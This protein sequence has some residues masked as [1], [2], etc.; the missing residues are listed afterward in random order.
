[1]EVYCFPLWFASSIQ[2]MFGIF[3]YI[4]ESKSSFIFIAVQYSIISINPTLFIHLV[5]DGELS[6]SQFLAIVYNNGLNNLCKVI[7]YPVS[8][9]DF[10]PR[11]GIAEL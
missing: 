4:L 11:G 3:T 7:W 6:C 5:I 1:M 9:Q 2:L 10:I 8:F